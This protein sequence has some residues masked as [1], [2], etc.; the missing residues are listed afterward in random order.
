MRRPSSFLSLLLVLLALAAPRA[1]EARHSIRLHAPEPA[2][3]PAAEEPPIA[4]TFADARLPEEGGAEPDL[5]GMVRTNVGVPFGLWADGPGIEALVPELVEDALRAAGHPVAG[6][7]DEAGARLNVVLLRSWCTGWQVY[8]VHVRLELQL[9]VAGSTEPTWAGVFEGRAK[10][11]IVLTPRELE[12]PY[13]TALERLF[14]ALASALDGEGFA[15]ATRPGTAPL[16]SWQPATA[17]R[18]AEP[19][20]SS[21]GAAALGRDWERVS[22]LLGAWITPPLCERY[23]AGDGWNGTWCL[24]RLRLGT[25][26]ILRPTDRFMLYLGA[27]GGFAWE[28][29]IRVV[30][31]LAEVDR[32]ESTMEGEFRAIVG[33]GAA[34]PVDRG[35]LRLGGGVR[36]K[37]YRLNPAVVRRFEREYDITFDRVGAVGLA[38]EL[39]FELDGEPAPQVRLGPR[40]AF[41]IGDEVA[42][43][44]ADS[45][46]EED[47][48]RAKAF[49]AGP[50]L[51]FLPSFAI[52]F[53]G[54]ALGALYLELLPS[55]GLHVRPA[56]AQEVLRQ[57]YWIDEPQPVVFRGAF[58][59]VIG[60][61]LRLGRPGRG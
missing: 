21:V 38:G 1:A 55:L 50:T 22:L 5:L 46:E 58:Y 7:T 39:R 34:L 61:E 23:I 10:G 57:S 11:P 54:A 16:T 60:G 31:D 33:A 35:E 32:P 19:A 28:T 9:F 42:I 15:S 25:R 29:D 4:V 47:R 8:K 49:A 2:S 43:L 24:G 37:A 59:I 6:E 41:R 48:A 53:P 17:T 40:F 27:N 30:H 20:S 13:A 3:P 18:A 12:G 26:V 14:E 36:L 45:A 56:A 44:Y 51:T 52:S